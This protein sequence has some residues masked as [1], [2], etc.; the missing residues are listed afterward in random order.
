MTCLTMLSPLA[1][2]LDAFALPAT[3]LAVTL[4]LVGC[5]DAAETPPAP[6]PPEI[7]EAPETPDATDATE[8][9]ADAAVVLTGADAAAA[10]EAGE[11][12]PYPLNV[13]LV[14]DGELGSMGEPVSLVYN[15]QEIKFCCDGCRPMFLE[16]PDSYLSKLEEDDE[17]G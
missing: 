8:D 3:V 4:T 12:T 10:V 15:G 6:T 9:E 14:A 2:R 5:G 16:D 13:C 17:Q 11:A 7:T 1:R